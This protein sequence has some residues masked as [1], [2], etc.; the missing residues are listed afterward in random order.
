MRGLVYSDTG[1]LLEIFFYFFLKFD[2]WAKVFRASQ[3]VKTERDLHWVE[4][5]LIF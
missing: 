3:R 2:R 1:L 5:G 4:R